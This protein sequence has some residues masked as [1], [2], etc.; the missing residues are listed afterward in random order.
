[1]VSYS[2]SNVL[3]KRLQVGAGDGAFARDMWARAGM[4]AAQMQVT[5]WCF[6]AVACVVLLVSDPLAIISLMELYYSHDYSLSGE[7]VPLD[8]GRLGE[9]KGTE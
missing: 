2:T 6:G 5:P 3:A 7:A 4:P 8:M 1:M 9:R